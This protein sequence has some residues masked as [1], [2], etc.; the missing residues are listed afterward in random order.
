MVIAFCSN[1][2]CELGLNA[3][4]AGAGF[5]VRIR[6]AGLEITVSHQTV[7]GSQYC[8]VCAKAARERQYADAVRFRESA[9]A[10]AREKLER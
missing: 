5:G 9:K 4:S 1:P 7:S 3:I 10:S 2:K 6:R 8:D